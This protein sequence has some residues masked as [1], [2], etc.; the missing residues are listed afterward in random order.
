MDP[1]IN[2]YQRGLASMAYKIFDETTKGSGITN[3]NFKRRNVYSSFIDNILGA[4]LP[5]MTLI[6]KFNI[7]MKYL[8]C[9]TDIFSRYSCVIPLK[10]KKGDTIVEGFKSILK[11]SDRKPNK[12]WVDHGKE[13]YSNQIKSF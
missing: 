8:L 7:R 1:K 12:I 6:S 13:F 4:D 2:R 3:E 10:N 9:V 5:D 11:N